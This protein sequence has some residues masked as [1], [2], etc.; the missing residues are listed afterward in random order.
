MTSKTPSLFQEGIRFQDGTLQTTAAISVTT[1]GGSNGNVQG[2]NYGVFGGLPGSTID[3]TNG[4]LI[5]APSGPGASSAA[6]SVIG[7]SIGNDIVDLFENGAG[8]VITVGSTGDVTLTPTTGVALTM[9][10][11]ADASD[12]ID[13]YDSGS[14]LVFSVDD[15]GNTFISG[16]LNLNASLE[17]A[18]TTVTLKDGAG[19]AGTSGQLLSSTG[20]GVQWI[21]VPAGTATVTAGNTTQAVAF[22]ATYTTTAAPI[23]VITPT[24]D[25]LAAGVPVGYWITYSGSAGARTGFTVNIQ[26]TLAGNVTFNYICIGQA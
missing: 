11:A 5:I 17:F 26:T 3:F 23:V 10:G 25:P 21:T 20:V 13:C 19:S 8:E 15:D 14:V 24:S 18:S 4:T 6:L 2:N 16:T 22:S 1:P 9:T 12:I 7:D